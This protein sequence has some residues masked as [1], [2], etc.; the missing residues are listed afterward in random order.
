MM[1]AALPKALFLDRDGVI[2]IDHGYVCTAERTEFVEGIFE[3]CRAA[4]MQGYLI[5]VVTNQ[6]GI[7]RG[8][9][10]EQDFHAYMDWMRGEFAA[11][12][13][14]LDAV[15]YCPHHP[16]TG[17][18]EYRRDCECRKPKPGMLRRAAHELS[19]DLAASIMLGDSSSDM[20]AARAGGVGTRLLLTGDAHMDKASTEFFQ[21]GSLEEV[22]CWLRPRSAPQR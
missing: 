22:L 9:Y 18:Q 16:D 19:L 14:P 3:L 4:R 11:H 21:V 1:D 8:Y 6:S 17:S 13:A 5:V 20:D 15:Y 12:G 10:S 7:A 2:N